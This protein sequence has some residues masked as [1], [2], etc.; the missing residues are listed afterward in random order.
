MRRFP[1]YVAAATAAATCRAPPQNR[2]AAAQF[3]SGDPTSS[4]PE[5]HPVSVIT[6]RI[7]Q[8]MLL[9]YGFTLCMLLGCGFTLYAFRVWFY[10]KRRI[11]IQRGPAHY[12]KGSCKL[13]L[14][15]IVARAP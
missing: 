9:E 13:H 10:N 8:E 12:I 2:P 14:G 6:K 1:P 7:H 15:M 4:E 5:A 3:L 11:E